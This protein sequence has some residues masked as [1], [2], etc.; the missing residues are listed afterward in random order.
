MAENTQ[1]EKDIKAAK[2]TGEQAVLIREK[3]GRMPATSYVSF[4]EFQPGFNWES[5]NPQ[6]DFDGLA[7]R[8][9]GGWE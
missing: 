5:F 6:P 9:A 1:L 7:E 3:Y 4:P 2:F 8:M